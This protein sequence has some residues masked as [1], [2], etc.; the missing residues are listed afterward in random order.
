MTDLYAMPGHLVRRYHQAAV[1]IFH[2]AVSALGYDLTPVQFAA[3]VKVNDQ[4][5][6]DQITLAGLIAYD[7]TTITGVVDRLV[8]KGLLAREVSASDRRSRVLRL[9]ADGLKVLR[10]VTPAVETAQAVMLQGLNK[11]E[12]AEFLRLLHK[13][14]LAVNDLSRAPLKEL[15]EV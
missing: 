11:K 7:R 6:I 13:A 12:A 9:S 4:P 2:K 14:T 3:L 1:A 10:K 8:N 5:G 15:L